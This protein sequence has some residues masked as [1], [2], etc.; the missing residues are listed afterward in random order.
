MA[1]QEHLIVNISAN[2]K[3][4]QQGLQQAESK[5]NQIGGKLKNIGSTLTTRFT[6]PMIAGAGAAIKMAADFDKSMTKIKTLVGIAGAEVD[7]MGDSVKTLAT[8]AG[9]S[10]SEAADA[11]FF[12]TSAGLRG[13]EAMQVLEASTK[14]AAIGLGETKTVADLATSAMNAYGSETLS[15][16]DATDVL[17]AAVREGKLEASELSSA[18]GQ[19]L[20]VASNMGVRFHEVGAAF[21]AMS[22]TGTN[23]AQAS[24]QLNA[25]MMGIMKPTEDA[26]KALEEL[27]LSS[28]GLRQQIKDKGLLSVL[29]TLKD[30]SERNSTAFERVFG[31][32]RALRGVLDLTGK[33]AAVTAEIFQRMANT[34]GITAEA[35]EE[36]QNSAEFKLRKGLTELRNSFT[37][38]GGILMQTLLP[39]IQGILNF[40]KNLFQGF[41]QLNPGVQ[42]F[43]IA[44]TSLAAA[45]PPLIWAIGSLTTAFAALNLATGGILLAIGAVA[46]AIGS[47]VEYNNLKNQI[48]D[49]NVSLDQLETNLKTVK[50][51]FDGSAESSLKI[52]QAEKKLA[53]EKLKLAK[54][55]RDLKQ[56]G[57]VEFF[58]YENDE[59][60]ALSAEIKKHTKTIENYDLAIKGLESSLKQTS[61][62]TKDLSGSITLDMLKFTDYIE[63]E[64]GKELANSF[65]DVV[66]VAKVFKDEL[67]ELDKF[68]PN[69]VTLAPEEIDLDGLDILLEKYEK[70]KESTKNLAL[71]VGGVLTDA[72]TN[73]A[74]G[75]NFLEPIMNALKQLLIRLVAAAAAAAV[76]S[77]L[78]PGNAVKSVGGAKGI[79]SLL[80]G[81]NVGEYANGGIISGPTLGLM[82]EYSGARSNPEVV[83]PLD[84]LKGMIGQTGQNVNV[85]GEFRIQG[86]DLVVALQRAERNRKRIL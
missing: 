22:R 6:L 55:N 5:L 32:V 50:G 70:L 18:M 84:K 2:T 40:V 68:D 34:S 56:G 86:Q 31:N 82:G 85:G 29:E 44:I 17:T 27:G 83:A 36:L 77:A 38:L 48:D 16:T 42:K 74:E 33:G 65:S 72:F 26:K 63:P 80:S 60:K 11:L 81:L 1:N 20:P 15:A 23:A 73:L 66:D 41:M 39:S 7:G 35:F 79:F 57:I 4:L 14:A 53:E 71:A 62:A 30:A 76:L 24:T 47:A 46:V 28:E 52:L 58:G 3:G 51:E 75:G 49:L 67:A 25:I 8:N 78:L 69:R 59:V 21:A 45:L 37:E 19:T 43:I 13:S 12:I 10:S 61:A 9:V 64:K 54:A